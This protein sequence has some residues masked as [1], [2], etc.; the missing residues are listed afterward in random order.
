MGKV[1]KGK[2]EATQLVP[3]ERG[4]GKGTTTEEALLCIYM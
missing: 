1:S 4:K 2:S 3:R